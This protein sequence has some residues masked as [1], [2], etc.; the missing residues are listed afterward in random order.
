MAQIIMKTNCHL[1]HT[2]SENL[3]KKAKCAFGISAQSW[4]DMVKPLI[5]S[6]HNPV[7]LSLVQ[8][9]TFPWIWGHGKV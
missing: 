2:H 3:S 7:G 1:G 9:I 5:I 8:T 4:Q 6:L